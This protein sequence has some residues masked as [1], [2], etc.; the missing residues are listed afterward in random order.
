[1]IDLSEQARMLVVPGKGLLAADE[2]T[3]TADARLAS[4]GI[5][6]SEEMRR[7][8]RDLFLAAPG[9]EDFLSGVILFSETLGQSANDG[10]PFPKLLAD[11]GIAP[12]VKV[13]EGTEPISEKSKEVITKGLIGLPERLAPYALEGIGF[14]KWRGVILIEG[15]K[16]PTAH[17][18]VENAKR[19]A[20]YA[21][22]VQ[23]AGMVPILEP[24]VLLEGNHSRLRAK[25]VITQILKTTFAALHDQAVD[26]SGLI[27][28]TSMAL[29][30]SGSGKT[31]TPEEVAEGTLEALMA[32][33]PKQVPGI[34]FLS[35]GQTPDQATANLA[36]ITRRARTASAP[37]PLTFSFARALQEEALAAWKGKDENV[38]VARTAFVDRLRKVSEALST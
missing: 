1:M 9:I 26:I 8:Y 33:V 24:E 20:T 38:P 30:G 6:P 14:T 12:V 25:N 11:K 17:A 5:E 13:D 32:S 35:G 3:H 18:L 4:C 27:I 22:E 28:K 34:V 29:S 7:K 21:L 16:L 31:D 19:L 36:A 23:R 15:D 2:S 10:T 37:W